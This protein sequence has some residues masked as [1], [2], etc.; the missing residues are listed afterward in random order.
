M[1]RK[2][3][4]LLAASL[5]AGLAVVAA[6]PPANLSQALEAQRRMLA[7]RPGDAGALNDL[8]N[9]LVLA[10]DGPAAEDAY[11]RAVDAAPGHAPYHYN[12]GLLLLQRGRLDQA[13]DHFQ[14]VVELT[15]ENAWAVYQV[16]AVHEKRGRRGAAVEW[17]GRAFRL[18]PELAFPDV[19]PHVIDSE[20]T[21]EAM[22]RGYRGA[23][24]EPSAPRYYEEPARIS[25]LLVRAPAPP[26]AAGRPAQPEAAAA[27]EPP[28]GGSGQ[29]TPQPGVPA[30]EEEIP[31]VLTDDDLTGGAVNQAAPAGAAAQRAPGS[32]RVYPGA[33]GYPQEVA[34][35]EDPQGRPD[36]AAPGERVNPRT[37]RPFR[38][39]LPSTGR[40]EMI[41][42]EPPT[43]RAG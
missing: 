22:L 43:E 11:Q 39:A 8:G 5:A 34:P 1:R 26:V 7:E 17:Y 29:A 33:V 28:R 38:P 9:L 42:V 35:G 30:V 3:P 41:F 25:A 6:T 37:G 13:L 16:G 40:L 18:D 12:L 10:G 2:T 24:A 23:I 14:Q 31:R 20:L 19:N 36:P 21:A 32:A 4:F 15:P 27:G